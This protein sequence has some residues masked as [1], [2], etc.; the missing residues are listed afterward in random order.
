M[1]CPQCQEEGK[2]SRVLPGPTSVRTLLYSQP[3]YDEDGKYHDH[4]RN[5]TTRGYSCSNGHSWS[6]TKTGSCWCGWKA[7][8]KK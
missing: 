4:D 6:E 1:F 8:E 3:Y 7:E 2:K 5:T